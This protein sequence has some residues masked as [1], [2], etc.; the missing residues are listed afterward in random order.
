MRPPITMR[1]VAGL[2]I[3][4]LVLAFSSSFAP[5]QTQFAELCRRHLPR[6]WDD[7]QAVA[8][9]DVDGDGDLDM[10][11]GNGGFRGASSYG[12]QNRLY[13]NDGT[14]GFKDVTASHLPK[15]RADTHAVALGDVDGDGDL[16]VVCGNG[17]P[18]NSGRN[19][20][21]QNRLYLNDGKG[22]F[23][24]AT[25]RLPW[26]VDLTAAV[27]LGDVDGDK[28]LDLVTGDWGNWTF[29]GPTNRRL[30]LNDGKGNFKDVTASR[31]PTDNDSTLGLVMGDVDG[32]RDLDLV[33]ANGPKNRLF[34]N[35][36]KGKFSDASSRLPKGSGA[37]VAKGDVDGDGDLDLVFGDT[38][39]LY[40]NDGKGKFT[41]ASSKL[42]KISGKTGA[43]VL[44]DV[45][46]DGD[47][48]LV[49]GSTL[50]NRLYLNDG[51]G[52]FTDASSRLPRVKDSVLVLGDV[53]GDRDL[54]LM[55]GNNKQ[56]RLYLNLHRHIHAPLPA[57]IGRN[58][59]LDFYAKPGYARMSQLAI[60]FANTAAAV[61][62]IQLPPLG[63]IGVSTTGM[64]FLPR[65]VLA[66]PAGKASVRFAIPNNQVLVGVTGYIQALMVHRTTPPEAHFT[67][68][69]VDR[70]NK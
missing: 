12:Q 66:S 18:L 37:T 58:Y 47:L 67:N 11:V 35:D 23:T 33:F 30:Y 14:G 17:A 29:H 63:T 6:V 28:D 26:V 55:A 57:A 68:L 65:V 34:L 19:S 2:P 21:E 36:G 42:P 44:G 52:S 5:A 50:Q 53:D 51:K 31:L 49:L 1:R 38:Y 20:G 8:L 48:D 70:I 43:V 7:T 60:P 45:D 62:R 41:D 32:D 25:S 4:A 13:L 9:G 69:V 16:D 40:L 22:K 64:I 39:R 46:E 10:V 24:D 54:D 59:H 15:D 61:P 56:N 27:A 3:F